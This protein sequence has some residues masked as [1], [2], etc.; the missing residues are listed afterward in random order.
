MTVLVKY[1]G[2]GTIIQLREFS[3]KE[4]RESLI[5]LTQSNDSLPLFFV[6]LRVTPQLC[7]FI[8]SYCTAPSR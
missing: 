5:N 3:V 6:N 7:R 1:C 8:T 2:G 4:S